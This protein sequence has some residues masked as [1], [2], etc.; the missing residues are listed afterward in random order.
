M[1]R[2]ISGRRQS[3]TSEVPCIQK[4]VLGRDFTFDTDTG[5]NCCARGRWHLKAA[6]TP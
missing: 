2:H 4:L 6:L 5:S 3:P 1:L